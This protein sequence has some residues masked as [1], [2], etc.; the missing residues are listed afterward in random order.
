[1]LIN[2]TPHAIVVFAADRTTV[3]ATIPPSGVVARVSQTQRAMAPLSID[4]HFVPLNK[5]TFGAVE[6]LPP[7]SPDGDEV[8]IVSALVLAALGGSRPD[9]VG[10][11]S[12]PGAV[13]GAKGT[14]QAGQML[15]C[16][17]FVQ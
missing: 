3:I 14:P 12:G 15:G 7:V 11:D 8:Y 9:V 4:G 2:M 6:G 13:R 10:P 1:M 17:G 16:I 5:N